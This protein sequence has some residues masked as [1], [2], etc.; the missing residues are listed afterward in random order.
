MI[1]IFKWLRKSIVC[2]LVILLQKFK[3]ICCYR[4]KP[5]HQQ[6]YTKK[7][8]LWENHMQETENKTITNLVCKQQCHSQ[9]V[10]DM[11]VGRE[12]RSHSD[13]CLCLLL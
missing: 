12:Y 8:K 3:M 2:L 4:P 9:P 7:V 10:C 11:V 5:L 13:R 1:M 6:L